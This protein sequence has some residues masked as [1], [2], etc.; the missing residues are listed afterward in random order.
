MAFIIAFSNLWGVILR[1]W[2]GTS[3]VTKGFVVAGILTLL[4]STA[5]FGYASWL[6]APP[7]QVGWV[8]FHETHQIA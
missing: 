6:A 7:T 3:A 5:I 8:E 4:A 2:R 1:E